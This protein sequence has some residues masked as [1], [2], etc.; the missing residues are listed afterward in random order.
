MKKVALE[1]AHK[2]LAQATQPQ[3][4]I[5]LGC[6]SGGM[7]VP[8]AKKYPE[9]HFIGYEWDKIAFQL[10]RFHTRKYANIKIVKGN[11]MQA[12]LSDQ[13]LVLCFTS[14]GIAQELSAK[15]LQELPTNS[16]IISSAFQ[17][18]GFAK[19]TEIAARTYGLMPIKVFVY[20]QS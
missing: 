8:L 5:D 12:P 2:I 1:E 6:G 17:L 3:N 4:I 16:F 11:F 18:Y 7:L 9:H 14:D 13:N 20:Q 10:A 19:H 15:L